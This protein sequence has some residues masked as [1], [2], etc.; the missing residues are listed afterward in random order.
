MRVNLGDSLP[1]K[2]SFRQNCH[3]VLISFA[4]KR[5]GTLWLGTA[6]SERSQFGA[7][8]A[9]GRTCPNEK[10]RHLA[11][12]GLEPPSDF[13]SA[14]RPG[15]GVPVELAARENNPRARCHIGA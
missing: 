9:L 11:H 6:S 12:R 5:T 13:E 10:E 1:S 2:V 14:L 8:E 7:V 3:S 4:R 15:L